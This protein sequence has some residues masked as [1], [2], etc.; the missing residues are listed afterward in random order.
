MANLNFSNYTHLLR[1]YTWFNEPTIQSYLN[2]TFNGNLTNDE[3]LTRTSV[4]E[5]TLIKELFES[6]ILY[7][8]HKPSV[9]SPVI[10]PVGSGVH[11]AATYPGIG[12]SV[13]NTTAGSEAI[14]DSFKLQAWN[15][16]HE[17]GLFANTFTSGSSV[18]IGITVTFLDVVIVIV[19]ETGLD[20]SVPP[21]LP[22]PTPTPERGGCEVPG[23]PICQEPEEPY[24]ESCD[25]EFH[26]TF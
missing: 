20:D 19:V 1:Y 23:V 13:I 21:S 14:I 16:D 4:A 8:F 24:H 11:V 17:T 25:V 9:M 7:L 6:D 2:A 5:L 10:T 18:Y 22:E 26:E 3:V 12:K 15:E